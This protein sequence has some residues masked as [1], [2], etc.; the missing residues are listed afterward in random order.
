VPVSRTLTPYRLGLFIT[1]FF[2]AVFL[3]VGTGWLLLVT[4]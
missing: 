3:V 1:L 2:L 4:G